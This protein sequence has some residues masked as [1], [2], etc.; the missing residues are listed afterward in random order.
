MNVYW[1]SRSLRDYGPTGTSSQNALG[2]CFEG[3]LQG[4]LEGNLGPLKEIR[5]SVAICGVAVK[6]LKLDM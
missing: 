5:Q 1:G 2:G 3:T 4:P 6:A